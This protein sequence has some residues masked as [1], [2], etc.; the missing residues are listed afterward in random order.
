MK[1]NLRETKI[2]RTRRNDFKID[3]IID[4]LRGL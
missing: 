4:Y 3:I 1:K 2:I